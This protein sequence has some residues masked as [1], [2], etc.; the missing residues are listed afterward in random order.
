MEGKHTPGP[1]EIIPVGD[2]LVKMAIGHKGVSI[3]TVV[4]ED[5][6]PFG[7]VFKEEDARLIAAA[8]DLLGACEK[9]VW[10]SS[11]NCDCDIAAIIEEGKAAI[12][13]AKGEG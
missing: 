11:G 8:P 2:G 4:G 12:A 5:V 10:A 6:T 13:K 7:A 1:W 3:L 9:L